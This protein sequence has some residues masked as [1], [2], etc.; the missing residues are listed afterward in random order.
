MSSI[1]GYVIAGMLVL[2]LLGTGYWRYQG[3][4]STIENQ[5]VQIENRDRKLAIKDANLMEQ[6]RKFDR[7]LASRVAETKL[8]T[9]KKILEK[10]IRYDKSN[11]RDIT[12]TRIDLP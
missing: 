8:E 2:S 5:K 4:V 1:Y 10:E 9:K 12:S 7:E 11:S 3:M 6:A